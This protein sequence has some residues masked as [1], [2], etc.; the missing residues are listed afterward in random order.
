MTGERERADR[1]ARLEFL[2]HW[3]R[4]RH[5]RRPA[6][7]WCAVCLVDLYPGKGW[8]LRT[9]HQAS[10]DGLGGTYCAQTFCRRHRPDGAVRRR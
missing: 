7:D 9:A 4:R 2:R 8:E 1:W 5:P 3:W 10:D 6:A